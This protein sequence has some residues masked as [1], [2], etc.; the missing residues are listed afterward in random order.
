MSL[1]SRV[2][3]CFLKKGSLMQSICIRA[4]ADEQQILRNRRAIERRQEQFRDL[5]RSFALLG[6]EMRLRIVFALFR[7]KELCPCDLADIIRLSIS[8]TSQHLRKLRDGGLVRTRRVGQ[9]IFYSLTPQARQW[10]GTI[11]ELFNIIEPET[12][13]VHSEEER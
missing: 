4:Q 2:P 7:E 5:S 1:S 3:I 13:R 9:T 8:A 6:S 10:I 11:F 12:S